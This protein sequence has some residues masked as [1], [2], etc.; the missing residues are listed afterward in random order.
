MDSKN[1]RREKAETE[2]KISLL[3]GEL[4]I[5][6]QIKE[7]ETIETSL[8]SPIKNLPKKDRDYIIYRRHQALGGT[9]KYGSLKRLAE[10]I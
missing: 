1:A 6:K 7:E 3:K 10:R 8:K 9:G 5:K 2:K 4:G